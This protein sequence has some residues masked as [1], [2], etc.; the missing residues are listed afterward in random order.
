MPVKE[1]EEDIM[2]SQNIDIS[3]WDTV[4]ILRYVYISV[5]LYQDQKSKL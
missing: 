1:E 2:T 3:S 5:T 4:Y